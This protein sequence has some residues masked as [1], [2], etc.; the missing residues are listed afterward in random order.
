MTLRVRHADDLQNVWRHTTIGASRLR[1][2]AVADD[3]LR[4]D[5][6]SGGF[7]FRIGSIRISCSS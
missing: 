4:N 5:E 2:L 1:K 7:T 6:L 3:P